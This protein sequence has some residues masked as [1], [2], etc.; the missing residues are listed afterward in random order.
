MDK[1]IHLS[2]FVQYLFEEIKTVRKS[3]RIIA[4]IL[5]ARSPRLSDIAREMSGQ[6]AANYKHIQRFVNKMEPRKVLKRLFQSEAPFMIG[7]P[8]E[9]PLPQAK[10]TDYV[11]T[12]SDGE[13]SG[14]EVGDY[15]LPHAFLW[16]E[17]NGMQD[18]VNLGGSNSYAL[19]TPNKTPRIGMIGAWRNN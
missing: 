1:F 14:Y 18:L 15:Y 8:T 19:R 10:K 9:M 6:E 5:K 7:D 4:G 3:T 12:L 13:T 17:E 16:T 11:G 2:R